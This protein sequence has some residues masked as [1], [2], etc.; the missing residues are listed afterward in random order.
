MSRLR[1]RLPVLGPRA[2]HLPSM[3]T[4]GPLLR[5]LLVATLAGLLGAEL[6][7]G[8]GLALAVRAGGLAVITAISV[9]G[10]A[11]VP[12]P[13]ALRRSGPPAPAAG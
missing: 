7:S 13:E 2:A 5:G 10:A 12:T 3:F 8:E 11:L 9:V 1:L 4:E 6:V